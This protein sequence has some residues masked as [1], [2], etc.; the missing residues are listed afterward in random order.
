MYVNF[1]GLVYIGR[2]HE[3]GEV[4]ISRTGGLEKRVKEVY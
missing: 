2:R 4:A 1:S 3:L